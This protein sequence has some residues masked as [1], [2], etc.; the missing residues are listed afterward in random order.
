MNAY[1]SCH[2]KNDDTVRVYDQSVEIERVSLSFDSPASAR[3]LA[4]RLEELALSMEI[5]DTQAAA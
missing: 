2:I 3:R 5:R 4:R 1:I